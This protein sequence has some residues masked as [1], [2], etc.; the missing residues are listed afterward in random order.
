MD[1]L[2]TQQSY[3]DSFNMGLIFKHNSICSMCGVCGTVCVVC[4]TICVV[5]GTVC[6]VCD[7]VCV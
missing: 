4:G 7:T 2:A 3:G 5:C 1:L 6:V